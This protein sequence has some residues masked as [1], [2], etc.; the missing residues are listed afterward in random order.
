MF[1]LFIIAL[2]FIGMIMVGVISGRKA[3]DA[4]SFFVADRKCSS[5]LIT[6]S[7]F[8]TI[9]GASTSVGIAGLGFEQGLTGAWWLLVGSI[10][11]FVLGTFFAEKVRKFRV[12]TLPELVEK[13]YDSRVAL[14]ASILIV[15]SWIG[16]IAGQIVAAGNILSVL[17]IA[18]PFGMVIFTLVFV[19]YTFL[20]GQYSI[21]RTDTLQAGI[22][23]FGIFATLIML[24]SH[25]GL[26]ELS[27]LPQEY[28]HFPLCQKFGIR[29]LFVFLIIV[30]STYVVGP[31]IY[32]RLFCAKDENTAK[33]SVFLTGLIIIPLAFAITLIGMWAKILF[34]YILPEQALPIVVK[35]VLPPFLSGIVFAALLCAIMSSADTCLLSV[36]TILTVDI[37][38]HFYP[39]EKKVLILSRLGIVILGLSSLILA[40][41][42]K[43]VINALLFAYAVYASGLILPIIAGFYKDRLKVTSSGALTAII[44]GGG[45]AL[46]GK[47]FSIEY[48]GL[49]GFIISGILLFIVSVFTQEK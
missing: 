34:P 33:N 25:F 46:F 21:I 22:I 38:G 30:G 26:E 47:L 10:G 48:L 2:Y 19:I 9:V 49:G 18:I 1:E 3:K 42:L 15:I 35:E 39:I 17:G 13:E 7:L 36:S 12:Y 11:L 5:I 28:F 44:A 32:S 20:G 14:V 31:D 40:L 6:G 8:A 37:I 27:Y 24:F 16:V 23:F 29:D 4:E 45:I 41:I 43:G